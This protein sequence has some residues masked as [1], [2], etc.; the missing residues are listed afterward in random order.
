MKTKEDWSMEEWRDYYEKLAQR[1]YQNYQESG[2]SRYD[3]EYFRYDTIVKAFN[4]Y[5][6]YKDENDNEKLR[7]LHNIDAYV[8]EHIYNDTYTKAEVMRLINAVRNM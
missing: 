3:R 6:E 5:L 7:R 8:A 2:E 4:G 1:A